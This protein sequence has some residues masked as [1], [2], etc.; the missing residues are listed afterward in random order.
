MTLILEE[1]QKYLQS[2][3]NNLHITSRTLTLMLDIRQSI[4]LVLTNVLS[5]SFL[6]FHITFDEM[7]TILS[8]QFW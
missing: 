1:Q 8:V 5:S 6:M 2:F 3:I 7:R 4:Y